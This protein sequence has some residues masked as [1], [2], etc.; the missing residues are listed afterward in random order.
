MSATLKKVMDWM[1]AWAPLCLAED[2]DRSGLAVGDPSQEIKKVLVALDVTEDVIQEAIAKEADLILTHHPML[3]FRKIESIRRDT[4]LG[5]RIFDLIEHH[6]AAYA[7]HTNLDIAKGGTNDVLAALG[8]LEDVQ[9]L[10]VTEAE[11]LK[12]I[13]V[14]VPMTHVEAVRQAMTDAGAGHI[15]AYS[16]CAFYTEGVGSFLPEAGTHPY[17]GTEGKLEEASEARVES[18]APEKMVPQIL[19]AVRKVHPYEEM[20]YDIYPVEQKGKTEGIGR[21]GKLKQPMAFREYAKLLKEKMGLDAIRLVG[22]GEKMIQTVALCTGAGSEYLEIA[23]KQGADLYLTADL[24]FH[25]AQR[26]VV[27][28]LCV[29]DLTHYASEVLIVPV[30]ADYLRKKAAEEGITLEVAEAQS[31][32]QTFWHI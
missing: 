7:A 13:V 6:I 12:K 32:G 18:I 1:E 26:A 9:I 4:P 2:W 21:I 25:E 31:N 24:K 5:S 20:A 29:A 14:Y 22:D 15:G 23:K 16:H 11:T 30:M 8:E 10:E 3:L 27:M 19:E 17:L 28:D